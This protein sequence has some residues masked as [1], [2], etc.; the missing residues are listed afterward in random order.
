MDNNIDFKD[1]WKKQS[2]SQPN[3]KD[4]LSRLEKFK[5]A[6]IRNLWITNISLIATCVFIIF[7]WY[8]YKPEYTST[9]IGIVLG[10]LAMVI[11]LVFY[12]QLLS[13]FKNIDTNQTNQEYLQKLISIRKKQHFIQSTML[14]LYFIL[15]AFGIGLYMYEYTLR[16]TLFGAI[17]TYGI[18]FVWFLFNWFYLRPK[19]MKKQE[20]KINILIAKFEEVNNQLKVDL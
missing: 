1:L 2:V 16:M 6:N 5:K 13:V 9:K 3:M 12:N 14:S 8:F 15:L 18:T 10:I 4:L 20:T 19:Q 7:I 17:L 11:Y